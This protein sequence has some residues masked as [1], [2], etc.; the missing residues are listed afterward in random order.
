M[1]NRHFAWLLVL[2]GL[3]VSRVLAQLIQAVQPVSFLPP[4]QA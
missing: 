3:F 4:F 1:A 2:A